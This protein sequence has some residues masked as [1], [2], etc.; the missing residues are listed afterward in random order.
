MELK[1]II[2]SQITGK[3]IPI[4][5]LTR[6]ELNEYY[7]FT[8]KL[9][10]NS[11]TKSIY[12]EVQSDYGPKDYSLHDFYF[13]FEVTIVGLFLPISDEEWKQMTNEQKF[14]TW[15]FY[16]FSDYKSAFSK[17]QYLFDMR[18]HKLILSI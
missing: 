9:S 5:G 18:Y 14:K 7:D 2:A 8:L 10:E 3:V 4:K 6:Y 13:Y 1:D 16:K 15:L 17:D 12:I 11:A